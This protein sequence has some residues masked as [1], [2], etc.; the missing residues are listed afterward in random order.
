MPYAVDDSVFFACCPDFPRW[1]QGVIR[2]K[3]EAVKT[4]ENPRAAGGKYGGKWAYPVGKFH[5][6]CHIDDDERLVKILSIV[7]IA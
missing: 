5:I 1:A 3:I 6:I 4:L 7:S 2:E